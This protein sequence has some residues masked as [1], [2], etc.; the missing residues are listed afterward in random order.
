[1]SVD[2]TCNLAECTQSTE[3]GAEAV[4]AGGTLNTILGT[5][6]ASLVHDKAACAFSKEAVNSATECTAPVLNLLSIH[7]VLNAGDPVD[8]AARATVTKAI[9]DTRVPG[10]GHF[11][12]SS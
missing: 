7:T 5:H 8:N 6:K 2:L 9:T 10:G 3:E 1:M 12:L 4:V 11:V